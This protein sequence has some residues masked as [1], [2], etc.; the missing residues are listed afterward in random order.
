MATM[1]SV[2]ER[3]TRMEVALDNQKEAIEKLDAKMEASGKDISDIRIS[4]AE[5][6]ARL[7]RTLC[8]SMQNSLL[9]MI[10]SYCSKKHA[11]L[12][13]CPKKSEKE[14][15]QFE[16]LHPL[17]TLWKQMGVG[18]KLATGGVIALCL[19]SVIL[20]I[21][22]QVSLAQLRDTISTFRK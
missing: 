17:L 14:D 1:E 9:T 21:Q 3:V 2:V 22:G 5:L 16:T 11:D 10:D 6:P 13:F 4:V 19:I 15:A 20:A 12:N 8:A 18:A 7:E